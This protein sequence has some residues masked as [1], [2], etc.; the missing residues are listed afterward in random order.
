MLFLSQI[1][2][3][4]SPFTNM[5]IHAFSSNGCL[6]RAVTASTNALPGNGVRQHENKCSLEGHSNGEMER[7]WALTM[8]DLGSK[9]AIS[10][11][12]EYWHLII[13][14][15]ITANV[16]GVVG[17]CVHLP[18]RSSLISYRG[19]KWDLEGWKDLPS[20]PASGRH[21]W[22]LNTFL[23]LS[24]ITLF[25]GVALRIKLLSSSPHNTCSMLVSFTPWRERRTQGSR[26]GN[27]SC[28]FNAG[29][30]WGFLLLG[31]WSIWPPDPLLAKKGWRNRG[32]A[33]FPM[34]GFG[35]AEG[36][37]TAVRSTLSHSGRTAVKSWRQSSF[38]QYIYSYAFVFPA[39][40]VVQFHL[41]FILM[42]FY[43][44]RVFS[45]FLLKK[46]RRG[47]VSTQAGSRRGLKC[48][49]G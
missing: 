44:W 35:C 37:G 43:F 34:R 38:G 36:N 14:S 42:F 16:L 40:S 47:F 25:V 11:K 49:L 19:K 18:L 24:Y 45:L 31:Q 17:C 9:A 30:R 2:I 1:K 4:S 23:T 8:A 39:C 12:L 22:N 10:V 13:G 21:Y 48:P 41:T 3:I 46:G 15:L 7:T 29:E 27:W 28:Y 20:L 32:S 33:S 6:L 26:H 5:S